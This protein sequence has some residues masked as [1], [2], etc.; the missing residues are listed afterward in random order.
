MLRTF[1]IGTLNVHDLSL[2]PNGYI[3]HDAQGLGFP[4]IRQV[5]YDKPGEDG[6]IVDAERY[7]GRILTLS[8]EVFGSTSTSYIAARKALVYA[9]RLQRDSLNLPVGTSLT[10]STLDGATYFATGYL[11]PP[12]HC[13]G[14]LPNSCPFQISFLCPDPAIYSTTLLTTGQFSRPS[15]GGAVFPPPFPITFEGATGGVG[16]FT[17]T[18]SMDTWPL[19]YLR[20]VHTNPR[21]MAQERGVALQLNYTSLPTDTIIVDMKNRT[22]ML[23]GVTS[24]I[25]NKVAGT[26][27]FSAVP[28][29]NT[30]RLTSSSAGDTG[31]A[32]LTAYSAYLTV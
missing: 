32:E 12:F 15:G 28:D 21:I 10:F 9:S 2:P 13:D 4:D 17:N 30:F 24:L 3:F 31:T 14:P 29:V 22:I 5:V 23:N 1:N 8:G 7:G 25:D 6:Q 27:F 18:G 26:D 19:L 11:K 20:G 16:Y